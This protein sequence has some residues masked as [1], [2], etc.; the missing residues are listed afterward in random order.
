M[1]VVTHGS[2]FVQIARNGRSSK[3]EI[4]IPRPVSIS[5]LF[6]L[7]MYTIMGICRGCKENVSPHALSLPSLCHSSTTVQEA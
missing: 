3:T 1:A 6:P 7:I 2:W 4:K 5:M